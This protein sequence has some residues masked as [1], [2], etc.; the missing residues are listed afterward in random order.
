[1]CK[2]IFIR[3]RDVLTVW[4]GNEKSSLFSNCP[5]FF[6]ISKYS[7]KQGTSDAGGMGQE[8]ICQFQRIFQP[9]HCRL[10]GKGV[11]EASGYKT[12]ALL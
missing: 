3:F 8:E 6:L 1:M 2:V 5:A 7:I 9:A 10:G 11:L 12:P 4:S